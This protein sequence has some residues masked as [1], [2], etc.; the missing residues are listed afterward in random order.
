[1]LEN[2]F[3][4]F[5]TDD[6]FQSPEI[7]KNLGYNE[8]NQIT[9]HNKKY[10]FSFMHE[11][12]S[13]KNGVCYY[14]TEKI[15][16][17]YKRRIERLYTTINNS[18]KII[19]LYNEKN[20]SYSYP[21][22]FCF[23]NNEIYI[24]NEKTKKN[25]DEFIDFLKNKYPNKEFEYFIINSEESFKICAQNL[26]NKLYLS[27]YILINGNKTNRTDELFKEFNKN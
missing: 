10:N 11:D 22:N 18:D 3:E 27:E 7:L 26:L 21:Y 2:N 20:V 15:I 12:I 9:N 5:I 6:L 4:N 13:N 19:L 17:K 16:N 23:E 8:K 25:F 1:M 24:D 14:D